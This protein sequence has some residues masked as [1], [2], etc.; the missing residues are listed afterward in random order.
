V[1]TA[2]EEILFST[3]SAWPIAEAKKVVEQIRT[4]GK[5]HAVFETGYGPSGLPHIG[6]FGEVVRTSWVRR[7]FE[8]LTGYTTQLIAFSDDMDALRRVPENIPDRERYDRFIGRPL[9]A[10]PDPYGTHASFAD[11]N[12]AQLK[13]FLDAFGLDYEFASA[14]DYYTSGRF[15]EA[16]LRVAEEHDAVCS[17]VRRTLRAERSATYS[18]FLPIHPITGIVMQVPMMEVRPHDDLIVWLDPETQKR[19]G[20]RITGGQCKLQWKA[21]WALRWRALGIDYEMFGKDHIDG[22]K[23]STQICRTIGGKAPVGFSYELFL[24]EEGQ[25]ISKSKGNGLTI[26]QW[27]LYAPWESLAQFMYQAPQSAKRLHFDVVPRAIDEYLVNVEKLR[28][29]ANPNN[30]AFHIHDGATYGEDVPVTYA[31]LLNLVGVLNTESSEIVWSYL[32]RYLPGVS[33]DSN[34]ML[35]RL[36]AH[37]IRFNRDVLAP[38]KHFRI[39]SKL[40]RESLRDLR[41]ELAA[42]GSGAAEQRIRDVVYA[43]GKRPAFESLKEWFRFLYQALLGRDDGPRFSTF[44]ALYGIPNTLSLIDAVMDDSS[45]APPN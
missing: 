28:R 40:E 26:E 29:Q 20:T 22:V 19:H 42:L 3:S 27:L 8:R 37:A 10:I 32:S 4:S 1:N 9:S 30:P 24:D 6:T 45:P 17:I 15:D 7:A 11:H 39:P 16:L 13:S 18:P 36:I 14:T 2:N 41:Q 31:T 33:A 43:V 34:P 38:S 44:V 12:N 21:D 25:K 5:K 23:V 35:D